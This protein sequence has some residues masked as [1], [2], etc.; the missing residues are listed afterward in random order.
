MNVTVYYEYLNENINTPL[1]FPYSFLVE[2]A[3]VGLLRLAIRLIRREDISSQIL[4]TL[5]IL[6]MMHPKV[7]LSCSKQISYGLHELVRTN[8]SDI[9]YSRDWITILTILQVVGAGANPPIVKPGPCLTMVSGDLYALQGGVAAGGPIAEERVD[10][11]TGEVYQTAAHIDRGLL[12][13][14]FFF[15]FLFCTLECLIFFVLVLYERF[16]NNI[17]FFHIV[18]LLGYFKLFLS[19]D[20]LG[21]FNK[22]FI[23]FVDIYNK[24]DIVQYLNILNTLNILRFMLPLLIAVY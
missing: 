18:T 1:S 10:T 20:C 13:F 19:L 15:S 7:L 22:C 3:V 17:I 23:S 5:R 9:H 2:R 21:G 14:L 11:E 6:L 12:I 4:I 8:A 16:L 24:Q